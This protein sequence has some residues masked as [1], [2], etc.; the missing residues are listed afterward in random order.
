MVAPQEAAPPPR[1]FLGHKIYSI[2]LRPE[3]AADGT[4]VTP[5]PLLLSSSA[6]YVAVSVDP[7]ILEEYL[8]SSDGKTKPLSQLPGLA[9]A[10]D[11]VGGA[12]GGLFGYQNQRDTMRTSFKLLKNNGSSD[13]TS[14]MF[15]PAFHDWVDFTLLPDFD[16][17]A[18]YF[19]ISVYSANTTDDGITLKVFN[20]RPPQLN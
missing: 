7:G 10:E 13:I 11:H 20:P 16:D 17:V 6:G 4:A 18:K 8:R 9:D 5:A 12:N 2:A 14:K 15:P 19:Y 1:D 3:R